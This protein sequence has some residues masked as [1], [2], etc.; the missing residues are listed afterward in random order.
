MPQGTVTN[1][2]AESLKD[3]LKRCPEGTYEAAIQ[4]RETGDTALL[5]VIVMGIVERY[6]EPELREKVRQGDDS[7]HLIEDLGIDS[8]TMMEIVILVEEV[9]QTSFD[10]A[11]L[12]EMRTVGDIKTYMTA[13][14]S[15]ADT[16]SERSFRVEDIAAV[17]PQQAPFLFLKEARLSGDSATG[18]YPISGSESFLEGHFKDNPV[19]PA[20]ILL[21][22]LGQLAV[23]HLLAGSE[24]AL[25]AAPRADSVFFTSCDGVRCHRICKPGDTLE[26]SVQRKRLREPM[27][28]Y[29]G[30]IT[31][32]GE[33]AVSAGERT[34]FSGTTANAQVGRAS[35]IGGNAPRPGSSGQHP[36]GAA[37]AEPCC[38]SPTSSRPVRR[39]RILVISGRSARCVGRRSRCGCFRFGAVRGSSRGSPLSGFGS[40]SSGG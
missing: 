38:G 2:E 37:P 29:S 10:N 34:L 39:R 17:L 11:E 5:P 19:F 6:V 36:P 21:E 15:G 14:L 3:S 32:N 33:K 7:L 8:L 1:E 25:D 12:R 16:P 20:S 4:Y 31:V 22:S 26:L 40:G 23:L 28:V 30:Q 13:R 24:D 35:L 9:L 27:A 18:S